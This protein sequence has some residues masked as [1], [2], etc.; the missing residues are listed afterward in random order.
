MKQ[1]SKLL[2]VFLALGLLLSCGRAPQQLV[3]EKPAISTEDLASEKIR[4]SIVLIESKNIYGTGF[5]FA[6]DKIAT[7]IHIVAQPGP[8]FVKLKDK[9]KIW[10]VTG[11]TAFDTGN[12][13]VI[14]KI[15]GESI[16]LSLGDSGAIQE[17][18]PVIVVGYPNKKYKVVKGKIH[19]A[20]NS[21]EWLRLSAKIGSGGSGSPTL[22]SEGL[23]V[24]INAAQSEHYGYDIPSSILKTL[25]AQSEVTEPL[26]KWQKRKLIR[27]SA[28]SVKGQMEYNANRYHKAI[29]VLDKAIKINAQLFYAYNKRGDANFALGNYEAA[30]ADYDKAIEINPEDPDAYRQRGAAKINLRDFEGAMLDFNSTIQIDPGHA[31]DYKKRAHTKFKIAEA[32][33]AQGDITQTLQLYQSAMEDCTQA[34]WLTPN[35]ADAYDNRG[36]AWFH[37]GEAETARGNIK[38]TVDLYKKA[39]DDYTQA[40]QIN[41]EHPYA[42]TNRDKAKFK[43]GNYE[44]VIVD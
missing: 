5:F 21:G 35:D 26:A 17:G 2:F 19:S 16:P 43:L 42:Y 40:L 24:G 10:A 27:A 14:L 20:S 13:L 32:K 36:W 7:N 28:L 8:I 11:V 39:I 31:D 1:N 23:V 34:I 6:P 9:E 25:L 3:S 15:A 12:D 38:R 44:E 18:E 33:T 37:L 29:A 30:I 4:D 41:P 22:N